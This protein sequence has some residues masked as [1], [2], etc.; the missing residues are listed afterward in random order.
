MSRPKIVAEISANHA[1]SLER[2]LALVDAAARAGADA[3]KLQT[4][5]PGTMVLDRHLVL[6]E[7]PWAGRN[8]YE[9]YEEAHTPWEWHEPL[10]SAGRALGLEVFSSPFDTASV[11]FLDSLGVKRLKIASFELVDVGLIRY[12]A[13]FGKPL[14]ISTGMAEAGEIQDAIWAAKAGGLHESDITLLKCTSAYPAGAEHANLLTMAHMKATWGCETG[15]SDHTPGIAVALIA[16]ALGATMIEKHLVLDDGKPTLDREFSITPTELA[17]L[18][19]EAPNAAQA[20][21]EPTYGVRPSERPQL[22]LRRTLHFARDLEAGATIQPGDLVTARP[23]RGLPCRVM[24][25]TIGR[26][27]SQAV[28]RG[29]P[30]TATALV[31]EKPEVPA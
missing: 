20:M 15:L 24:G 10:I 16:A 23:A 17:F 31:V 18:C 14:I 5:V 19:K 30:V 2:A 12:A 28:K 8:L 21:G 26:Q 27:V 11:Q 22:A 29:E 6:R 25:K 9:L 13:G 4:W 7:G 1:G 3:V